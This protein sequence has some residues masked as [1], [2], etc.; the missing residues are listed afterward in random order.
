MQEEF[1]TAA[2]TRDRQFVLVPLGVD[3]RTP[4]KLPLCVDAS[5]N[6]SAGTRPSLNVCQTTD[7]QDFT[8]VGDSLVLSA[9]RAG[10]GEKS[11]CLDAGPTRKNDDP[12]KLQPCAPDGQDAPSQEFVERNGKFMVR[13]TVGTATPMCLDVGSKRKQGAL[14]KIYKCVT[15]PNQGLQ[16]WR[17]KIEVTDTIEA[18]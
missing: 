4:K 3:V 16:H 2:R 18:R 14:L 5:G 1:G 10:D 15:T 17:G 8:R 7:N 11:M 6:W 9:T 13:D 12:V